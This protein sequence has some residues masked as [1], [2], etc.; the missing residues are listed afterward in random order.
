MVIMFT[1]APGGKQYSLTYTAMK[2]N[3]PPRDPFGEAVVSLEAMSDALKIITRWCDARVRDNGDIVAC[4]CLLDSI[5]T[6]IEEY[7]VVHGGVKKEYFDDREHRKSAQPIRCTRSME[8][9]PCMPYVSRMRKLREREMP[10][11]EYPLPLPKG[12][13]MSSDSGEE[14][15]RPFMS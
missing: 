5:A 1:T 9:N 12:S 2:V 13:T 7:M 8:G 6:H 10:P 4:P 11:L 14:P 3:G 15:R